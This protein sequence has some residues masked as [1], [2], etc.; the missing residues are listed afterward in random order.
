M[1]LKQLLNDPIKQFTIFLSIFSAAALGYN[2][3]V[4]LLVHL[5]LT[6]GFSLVLYALYSWIS[7]KHKNVWDT[8]VTGL[9]LF[10]LLRA[11]TTFSEALYPLLATFIA[12]TLKFFIEF[13]GSPIVNPAVGGLLLMAGI[14]AFIPG[15]SQPIISWWGA[16]FGALSIGV[17][18][19]FLLMTVWVLGGF[20]VWKKW[21]IFS[22]FL[23]AYFLLTYLFFGS[24]SGD[25][26]SL[27]FALTSSTVYFMASIMLPEPKTSPFLPWKQ[28]VFGAIAAVAYFGFAFLGV[29]YF[30]LFAIIVANLFNASFRLKPAPKPV[31]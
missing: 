14:V 19:S 21:W 25:L 5:A 28:V 9:L 2:F 30:E 10:L 27:K 23:V 11:G 18:V 7:E 15:M 20:Y 13:R 3:S 8:V 16:S 4:E 12:I 31:V 22:S 29:P 26:E 1:Q 17:S 6:L 24:Y